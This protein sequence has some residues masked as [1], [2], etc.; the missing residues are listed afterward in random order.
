[1]TGFAAIDIDS[2]ALKKLVSAVPTAE[3]F[4]KLEDVLSYID[5]VIIATPPRS[6]AEVAL[7]CLEQGKHVLIEKPMAMSQLEAHSLIN[8]ARRSNA[9]LMVGHTFEYDPA[10]SE[11]KRRMILGE[12][13]HISHI[14]SARLNLGRHQ[15]DINVVW[16]LVAHDISIMNYLL[17]SIP[18]HVTAW[19]STNSALKMHDIAYVKLEYRSEGTTGYVHAS[20]LD[21]Q[22][23]REV[24]VV[25]DKKMAVYCNGAQSP[26]TIFDRGIE[27]IDDQQGLTGHVV[28]YRSGVTVVPEIPPEEPL[29]VE[30]H[31][32]IDCIARS[33]IPRSS[34]EAGLAV[35]AVLEAIDKALATGTT[36]NVHCNPHLVDIGPGGK[37]SSSRVSIGS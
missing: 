23:V 25:G 9:T 6:H 7:R 1:L 13:G 29:L 3:C 30:V 17:N 16:D 26:L 22:K 33:T 27:L 21:P 34:G 15:R 10:I 14:H 31:H 11:L 8:A 35:V 12:L 2:A 20:W 18:T 36:V 28:S 5:A 24:T 32:F 37:Q 4:E 19:A